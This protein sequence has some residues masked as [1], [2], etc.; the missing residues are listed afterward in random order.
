MAEHR[1]LDEELFELVI[2]K[3]VIDETDAEC[4]TIY[5]KYKDSAEP[6]YSESHQQRMEKLIR[7]SIKKEKH[8]GHW[9]RN[10][11]A[12]FI[13]VVAIGAS[14]LSVEAVRFKIV[15]W[16]ASLSGGNVNIS[17]IY[18]KYILEKAQILRRFYTFFM[19]IM[20][21]KK[22]CCFSLPKIET[23]F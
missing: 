20:T 2:K 18:Q 17:S 11:V 16:I 15:G 8:Y 4:E 3:A 14:M 10:V 22:L 5:E 23:L 12:V 13:A 7:S 1:N 21:I 6:H 19:W 9:V